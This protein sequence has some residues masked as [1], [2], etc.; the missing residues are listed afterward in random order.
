M[1]REPK[2]HA[3][4]RVSLT[5]MSGQDHYVVDGVVPDG[6]H[7]LARRYHLKPLRNV[8]ILI[9]APES[10]MVLVGRPPRVEVSEGSNGFSVID[11]K[12]QHVPFVVHSTC[13]RC[14]HE[15]SRDLSS[16]QYM[17]YPVL[18]ARDVE[19]TDAPSPDRVYFTCQDCELEW[20]VLVRLRAFLE[21]LPDEVQD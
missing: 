7:P 15:E 5:G 6:A 10:A 3:G 17:A 1:S 16:G 18:V 14:L 2:F 19:A 11:S 13:S 21:V 12:R 20:R 9:M 8:D 4:D